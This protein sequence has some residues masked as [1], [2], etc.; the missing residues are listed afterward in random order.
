MGYHFSSWLTAILNL[1]R[2]NFKITWSLIILLENM[3]KKFEMNWTK[4]KGSCQSAR[5]VVTHDSKSDLPLILMIFKI[6]YY[7]NTSFHFSNVSFE[8]LA[9]ALILGLFAIFILV[10][11]V[12]LQCCWSN[13][14]CPWFLGKEES[15]KDKYSFCPCVQA[16]H[17]PDSWQSA[18]LEQVNSHLLQPTDELNTLNT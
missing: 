14:R 6:T 10:Y 13:R 5:K 7:K 3:H 18:G 11:T 1:C 2:I 16:I 15:S 17:S 4:I 8:T 12:C 9:A